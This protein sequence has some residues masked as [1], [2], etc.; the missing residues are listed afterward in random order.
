MNKPNDRIAP[1]P[2]TGSNPV[3]MRALRQ[4]V[5]E[6]ELYIKRTDQEEVGIEMTCGCHAVCSCVPVEQCA[7]H[8]VCSCDGVCSTDA[9]CPCVA[10]IHCPHCACEGV[11]PSDCSH[12][13]SNCSWVC[14]C[15][16]V[17]YCNWI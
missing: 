7:C 17:C 15:N 16:D 9:G 13:S 8:S 11:C 4:S 2:D 6:G 5:P 12:C 14:T 3:I 1:I 10:Y